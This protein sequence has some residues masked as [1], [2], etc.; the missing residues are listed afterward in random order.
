MNRTDRDNNHLS[1]RISVTFNGDRI[2]SA[3]VHQTSDVD[4]H[5]DAHPD[6]GYCKMIGK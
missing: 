4:G 2:V 5:D 3:L 1:R 6:V